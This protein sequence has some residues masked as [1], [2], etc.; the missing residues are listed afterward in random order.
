MRKF[1]KDCFTEDNNKYYCIAKVMAFMALVG[2]FAVIIG[3]ITNDH[4]VSLD[5]FGTNLAEVLAGCG[6]LIFGKQ[7]S[8]KGPDNG[9]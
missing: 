6:A 3:S 7:V 8:Q 5:S 1:I 4:K 9:N 2:F